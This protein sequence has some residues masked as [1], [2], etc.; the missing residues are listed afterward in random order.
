MALI[1]FIDSLKTRL[2]LEAGLEFVNGKEVFAEENFKS[3]STVFG[4]EGNGKELKEKL[5]KFKNE[6]MAIDPEMNT[7]AS[8]LFITTARLKDPLENPG[9]TFEETFFQNLPAVGSIAILSKFQNEVIVIEY[10]LLLFCRNKI[11][12]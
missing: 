3:V 2:K 5:L 6:L 12:A 9:K 1:S 4:K 10:Q 11:L 7:L 8:D